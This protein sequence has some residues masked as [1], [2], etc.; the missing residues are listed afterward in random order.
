MSKQSKICKRPLAA[1]SI[2]GGLGKCT[3]HSKQCDR[4]PKALPRA[5]IHVSKFCTSGI[6]PSPPPPVPLTLCPSC[7]P[8]TWASSVSCTPPALRSITCLRS[9]DRI[10]LFFHLAGTGRYAGLYLPTVC[11][12]SPL[13]GAPFRHVSVP[14]CS[15]PCAT[16]VELSLPPPSAVS[17]EVGD[18]S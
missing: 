7:W 6:L 12:H 8:P 14:V 2:K 3:F 4:G 1:W 17:R 5:G 16:A 11:A 10:S 18:G 9:M 13:G 15:F